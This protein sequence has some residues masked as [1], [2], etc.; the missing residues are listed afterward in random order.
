MREP[1]DRRPISNTG[2]NRKSDL[3][4]GDSNTP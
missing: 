1:L 4:A 2:Y 3:F